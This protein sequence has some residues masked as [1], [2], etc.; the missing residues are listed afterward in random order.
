M[1]VKS[2]V[3]ISA[4]K[5]NCLKLANKNLNQAIKSAFFKILEICAKALPYSSASASLSL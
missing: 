5:S 1:R 3:A 4:L 2:I